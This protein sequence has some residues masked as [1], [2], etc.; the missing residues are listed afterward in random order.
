MRRRLLLLALASA[1]TGALAYVAVMLL[2]GLRDDERLRQLTVSATADER[3]PPDLA[4]L[5]FGV[6]A[7]AQSARIAMRTASESLDS[8]VAAVR[9]IGVA[10]IQTRPV[11]VRRPPS[12]LPPGRPV[13]LGRPF[14][15]T[16]SVAV[17]VRELERLGRLI[18]SAVEAG[19][20]DVT[21][22]RFG[23]AEPRAVR[24]RL[25]ADAVTNARRN[26]RAM[27]EAAGLVLGRA[28]RISEQSGGL[29]VPFQDGRTAG[30]AEAAPPIER[31]TVP[32]TA[33]VSVTFAVRET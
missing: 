21:G 6:T 5:S 29:P 14:V 30:S 25:V 31:G 28:I 23:L 7:R 3:V 11:R 22:P 4:T 12:R 33:V 26:G 24:R 8:V 27:A 9:R 19:A 16:Q 32:V 10:E 17:R 15:A 13:P 2:V 20:T 18:D 1:V